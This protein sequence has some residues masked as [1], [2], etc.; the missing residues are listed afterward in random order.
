MDQSK[1]PENTENTEPSIEKTQEKLII[2][3][4]TNEKTV[5]IS[6]K[7][8][9]ELGVHED[10]NGVNE[11]KDKSVVYEEKVKPVVNEE[12]DKP[13]MNE[14]KDKPV[15]NEEKD[16]PVVNEEKDKPAVNEE[17]D[18]P[19][20]NEEKEKTVVNEEGKANHDG[21]FNLGKLKRQIYEIES[22]VRIWRSKRE[23]LNAQVIDMAKIRNQKNLEVRELI[24]KANEEKKLRNNANKEISDL[25]MKKSTL[26]KEIET[27]Q[28]ELEKKDVELEKKNTSKE[29]IPS[30]QFINIKRLQKDIK[31]LEWKLQTISNLP[32]DQEREIV[33]RIATLDEQMESLI[34]FREIGKEKRQILNGL[35]NGRK[36]LRKTISQM[37]KRVRESRQH[38]KTMIECFNKANIIRKEADSQHN[39]IQKIKKEADT[40]H[41]EYVEKI[42]TKK[43]L[44]S[45]I[46]RHMKKQKAVQKAK[47]REVIKERT[48]VALQR[49]KDGKKISFDEFKA[50]IDRGLI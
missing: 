36:D 39:S 29:K 38:H 9:N 10:A 7:E 27:Y 40:I 49:T 28:K 16:K 21:E 15:V 22:E 1:P 43:K 11:E 30:K 2:T 24:N 5:E 6:N 8:E 41:N 35:R 32:L 4:P 14:D 44:S 47:E 42:K 46:S 31:E 50:L 18:K 33:D 12:K 20:V 3:E 23:H 37:N 19:D 13:A 48:D 34:E 26:T 25:K 17:K 45:K